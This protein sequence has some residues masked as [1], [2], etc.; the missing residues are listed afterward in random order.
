MVFIPAGD[1]RM[2]AALLRYVVFYFVSSLQPIFNFINLFLVVFFFFLLVCR[3]RLV[4]KTVSVV[5]E[6][7]NQAADL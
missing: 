5:A 7:R 4:N 6:Q 1:A 3:W 2:L